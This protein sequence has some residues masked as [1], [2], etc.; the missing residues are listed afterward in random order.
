[1]RRAVWLFFRFTPS[2]RDVEELLAAS[3]IDVAYKTIRCWTLK[4]CQLYAHNLERS[5]PRPTGRWRLDE[6]VV[7]ILRQRM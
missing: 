3:G 5:R 6:M 2:L 7:K 1:M 4:F